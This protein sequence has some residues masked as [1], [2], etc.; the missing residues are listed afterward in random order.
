MLSKLAGDT[1]RTEVAAQCRIRD[2]KS[3]KEL[4]TPLGLAACMKKREMV[5][6]FLQHN[7]LHEEDIKLINNSFGL[8]CLNVRR[9]LPL[10][11]LAL[12]RVSN[13]LSADRR[14]REAAVATLGLP[15]PVQRRLLF[16]DDR[17]GGAREN[18]ID[19]H[20]FDHLYY[21]SSHAIMILWHMKLR[22]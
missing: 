19:D 5:D 2:T 4:F 18:V 13:L 12:V 10:N 16:Q 17:D 3:G 22:E 21:S 11:S 6:I 15:L 1:I 7:F 20:R 14:E 8:W 9:P